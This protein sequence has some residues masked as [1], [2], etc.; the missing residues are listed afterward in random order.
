MS[1]NKEKEKEKINELF[2]ITINKHIFRWDVSYFVLFLVPDLAEL[3]QAPS[4]SHLCD[5]KI[6]IG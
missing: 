2:F 4:V 5:T 6:T 3:N 1:H